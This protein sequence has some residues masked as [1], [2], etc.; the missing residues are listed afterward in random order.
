MFQKKKWMISGLALLLCVGITACSG[1][2]AGEAGSKSAKKDG[3]AA[4]ELAPEFSYVSKFTSLPEELN[5]YDLMFSGQNAYY[6]SYDY[7][8][9]SPALMKASMA[10]GTLGEGE[11]ACALPEEFSVNR[12]Y[13]DVDGN[14]Y[15]YGVIE[16]V[17]SE[18][19]SQAE[20]DS[21]YENYW[22]NTKKSLFKFD[23]QGTPVYQENMDAAITD[24]EYFYPQKMVADAKGRC[25][26][27][28][29]EAGI[30][31]FDENGKSAGTVDMGMQTWV[32]G[33]GV[34][35]DGKVYASF[36]QY[37]NSG[38]ES[39][40][41]E[42]EFEGKKLGKSFK[43]FPSDGYSDAPFEPGT[44]KDLL[45]YTSTGVYEYSLDKEESEKLLTWLDCDVNGDTVRALMR[46]EDGKFY[47]VI[48]DYTVG[49]N[50]LAE[51]SK[52]RTE[53]IA[54]RENLTV[55]VL[56]SDGELS[57]KVVRFNKSNDKYR[58]KVK[59]YLDPNN[60]SDTSYN[61]AVAALNNDILAGNAPDILDLSNLDAANLAKKGVLEDLGPY[62]DNSSNLSRE[63]FLDR[64][65]EAATLDGKLV[66]V[67]SGFTLQT[68]AAKKSIVG[69]RRGW[70]MEDMIALSKQ[71]PNAELME[72][73]TKDDI[74]QV[75]LRLNSDAFM[76]T[77]NKSC[78]FDSQEFKNLL[79]FASSFP[80]EYDYENQRLTPFKLQDNS[81]LLVPV[82]IYSFQEV[83]SELA[84]FGEEE[85]TFIG[86]PS[87]DGGNG[88]IINPI[89]QYGISSKSEHKDAA[90]EFLEELINADT[91]NNNFFYGFSSKKDLYEKQKAEALEVHYVYDENGDVMLDEFGD[92]VYENGGGYTMMGDNGETWDY[93]YRPIKAEEVD[94][95][96]ILLGK[97][98]VANLSVDTEVLQIVTEE[99]QAYFTGNKSLDDVVGVIQNRAN[100]YIK[101]N[102]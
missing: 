4:E 37:N 24:G 27:Y 1:K 15:V 26:M 49:A 63:D 45:F 84:Y 82:G 83:Q 61:D 46:A 2:N 93:H 16:P 85:A 65:L 3:S 7:E 59:A 32:S 89:G 99:A 43:N 75:M 44:E 53:E 72:Y 40:V 5:A 41:A 19:A 12:F 54:Q 39:V 8:T 47:A 97:A 102:Y 25:Y 58:I 71:Y 10:S 17:L 87:E 56:Y 77:A 57:R 90:W 30:L 42:I 60:W 78:S 13:V 34:A 94:M 79:Q 51:L 88:C 68:I 55:G 74:L 81:L 21:F 69:D 36:Q 64:L 31:L 91:E 62:L 11:I 9:E 14:I 48:Q 52:V 29:G 35:K 66:Y 18:D 100:L 20:I 67:P 86:F 33:M 6:T 28:A 92:P 98:R 22:K 95:V 70:T 80:A 73:T 38:V 76:D 23:A 50:E 96:E 101:E